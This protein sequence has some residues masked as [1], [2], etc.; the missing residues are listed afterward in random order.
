M[1]PETLKFN[2]NKVSKNHFKAWFGSFFYFYVMQ[3][4]S[5]QLFI[6]LIY[7]S[8]YEKSIASGAILVSLCTYQFYFAK[9]SETFIRFIKWLYFPSIF[10]DWTFVQEEPIQEKNS[11]IAF[12]PHCI[13]NIAFIWN[14]HINYQITPL[15]SRIIYNVPFTGIFIRWLGISTVDAQ[16]MKNKMKKGQNIGLLPGGFEEATLTSTQ[17]NRVYIKNRKGFIKYAL[18]YGYTVYPSYGFGENK[19]YYTIE[20][21]LSFRLLLNKLKLVGAYF[22]SKYGWI[23]HHN[24]GIHTVVGKGI[25]LPQIVN[26]TQQD[27]NKYHEIYLEQLIE[28]FNKYKKEY[29]QGDQILKIY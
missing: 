2:S 22:I 7:K 8:L 12:H 4:L 28:L 21:F 15:A 3:L 27:V 29:N 14:N 16:N 20:K 19:C 25:K 18:Q 23:P 9:R 13:F 1:Q 11:M 6:Y 24:F 26:P 5:I 10:E 17:E